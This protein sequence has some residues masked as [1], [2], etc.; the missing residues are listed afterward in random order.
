MCSPPLLPVVSLLPRCA[1]GIHCCLGSVSNL[2]GNVLDFEVWVCK[3]VPTPGTAGSPGTRAC[4][5]SHDPLVSGCASPRAAPRPGRAPAGRDL[6]GIRFF[7]RHNPPLG[8]AFSTRP[9][10]CVTGFSPYYVLMPE[11]QTA[12]RVGPHEDTRRRLTPGCCVAV[13][14]DLGRLDRTTPCVIGCRCV[15]CTVGCGRA[16]SGSH[17]LS[18]SPH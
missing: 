7:S 11:F 2:V 13:G 16:I 9:A 18:M 12:I 1:L 3:P 6:G 10:T 5:V 17:A 8:L 14:V 15:R 4:T